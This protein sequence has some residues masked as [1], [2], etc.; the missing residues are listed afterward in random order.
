[1]SPGSCHQDVLERLY[2]LKGHNV[3]KYDYFNYYIALNCI[4]LHYLTPELVGS[5]YN[6]IM[7][8][9]LLHSNWG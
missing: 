2:S 6:L 5:H 4:K 7:Q 9:T 3:A 8:G 1:M